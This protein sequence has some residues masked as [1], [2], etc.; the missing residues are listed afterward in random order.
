MGIFASGSNYN[1][2]FVKNYL[3]KFRSIKGL[4]IGI[5]DI[6]KI[7]KNLYLKNI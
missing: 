1:E 6:K 2:K 7:K 4:I 5:S 3:R